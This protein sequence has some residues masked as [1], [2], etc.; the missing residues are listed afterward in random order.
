MELPDLV[1]AL[2]LAGRMLRPI[3]HFFVLG[4]LAFAIVQ[5]SGL[6][7]LGFPNV[8]PARDSEPVVVDEVRR[9]QLSDDW[10]AR[11]G[12]DPS[13][14][15]MRQLVAHALDEEILFREALRLGLGELDPVVRQRLVQNMR[16]LA[17]EP[18]PWPD[19]G[20]GETRPGGERAPADDR[21]RLAE[22][23]W[24]GR[25]LALDMHR[26][27]LVV[28]RRLV[29]RMQAAI[30]AGAATPT[31]NEV[32]QFVASNSELFLSTGRARVS[33]AFDA[34]LP[35]PAARAPRFQGTFT[36]AELVALFGADFGDAL[37]TLTPG[38]VSGPWSGPH[39]EAW[40][41]V[42]E[43]VPPAPHPFEFVEDRAREMLAEEARIRARRE[44]M[45][46][47]RARYD[48][49]PDALAVGGRSGRGREAA[50]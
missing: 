48:V 4:G 43:V 25:A 30:D 24:I 2:K 19:E 32:R 31:R 16:F 39:G 15:D 36:E 22:E 42:E 33:Y 40:V 44:T 45:R 20:S 28:R 47:L 35:E 18:M 26:S 41:R 29:Q 34:E 9:A 7:G 14:A 6:N 50:G 3:L 38:D 1:S 17:G 11:F 10:R 46:A 12:T 23:K 37:A 8:A 21:D 5:A 49:P 27:D 13:E